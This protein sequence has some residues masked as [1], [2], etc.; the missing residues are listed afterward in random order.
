[1]TITIG[2]WVIPL[3]MTVGTL[4]Y[5][6]LPVRNSGYYGADIGE[7]FR[8]LGFIIVDLVAWLIWALLR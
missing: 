6:M 2:W 4:V 7:A 5:G 1:M 8:L 3:L